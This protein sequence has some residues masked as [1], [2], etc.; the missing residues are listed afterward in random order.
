MATRTSGTA[1]TG[2]S[3]LC[4]C[5]S[6][7]RSGLC[8]EKRALKPAYGE[9]AQQLSFGIMAVNWNEFES[10]SESTAHSREDGS[11]SWEQ[12]LERRNLVLQFLHSD[13]SLHHL[14]HQRKKAEL[15]KKCCFYLEIEPKHMTVREHNLQVRRIDIL[16]L[17]DPIQWERMKQVG[18]K[19]T[20]IQLL[21]LTELLEQ[22]ERG[23]EELNCCIETCD[24]KTFLSGWDRI[25]QRLSKLSEFMETLIPLQVPGQV[26]VKHRLVTRAELTYINP[27]IRLSLSTKMPLIFDREESFAHKDWAKLK[28]FDE[29]PESGVEQCELQIKILTNGS[30]A[31]A[32]YS[33]LQPVSSN[34]CIVQDLQ[35][36]RSYEFTIRRS[37]THTFVFGDWHDSITLKTKTDAVEDVDSSTWTLEG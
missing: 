31:E 12:Y 32:G 5:G 14:H 19:Q 29:N 27:I 28:W 16:E 26:Y 25:M 36:G 4:P 6:L 35:P 24:M 23:R 20:E 8:R 17:I 33:R 15:L 1:E 21:L 9:A 11:A 22:L 2:G 13:L 3:R 10:S 7:L 34:V 18:K 37:C 30:Q